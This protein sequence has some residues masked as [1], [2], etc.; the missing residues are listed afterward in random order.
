MSNVSNRHSMVPFVS[1]ESKAFTG[2]RLAK[3]GYKQTTQMTKAGE[4]APQSVCVS[5]PPIESSEIETHWEALIPHVR[6]MLESAQDGIVRSLY[7]SAHH[8]CRDVTDDE[9]SVSACIG[10]LIAQNEGD[11]LTKERIDRW[12]ESEV[13]ENLSVILAEKLGFT[14]ITPDNLPVIEK[15]VGIYKDTLRML[16][17]DKTILAEKQIKGCRTAIGL[18]SGADARTATALTA[19]LDALAGKDSE[20]LI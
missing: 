1:G 12:F 16:S 17:S 11:R 7:E 2:Q 19:K 9:I 8:T 10:Y 20:F 15:H 3:V 5:I 14:D 4:K 13:A 18:A 6:V